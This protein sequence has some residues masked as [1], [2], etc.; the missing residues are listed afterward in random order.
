M[1]MSVWVLI[2][3]YGCVDNEPPPIR[4]EHHSY[5]MS[6]QHVPVTN[7]EARELGLDLNGDDVIDNQAG[8]VLS[9]LAGENFVHVQGRTDEAI[10]RGDLIQL[11]D[12]QLPDAA[13][14]EAAAGFVLHIGRDPMPAAC[15]DAA[16]VVCRRHLDGNGVFALDAPSAFPPLASP[17]DKHGYSGGPGRLSLLLAVFSVPVRLDL[18]RA[19]VV[20]EAL[21]DG[22]L[23]GR[24]GGGITEEDLFDK[25]MPTFLP[26][27]NADVQHDCAALDNP[28]A[29]DC[30]PDSAGQTY[31]GLFDTSPKD[32]T[33][34]Y[35]ELLNNSLIVS[36]LS[37]DLTFDGVPA[38]SIG[39][40]FEAVSALIE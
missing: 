25:L 15:A 40:G 30:R 32:C 14:A 38:L 28:P 13:D 1:R 35:D 39:V 33:V 21:E 17:R 9:T 11:I 36:L 37:R 6:R 29:C 16:D 7:T 27:V 4:G 3:L 20:F 31:L 8:M 26:L 24:I 2:A 23:R 34:S 22:T 5:V 12:V 18:L 10:D 19:R